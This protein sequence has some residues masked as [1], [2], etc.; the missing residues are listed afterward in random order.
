M[1]KKFPARKD[2]YPTKGIHQLTEET[3]RDIK[4]LEAKVPHNPFLS[5]VVDSITK[6]L[7]IIKNRLAGEH[8]IDGIYIEEQIKEIKELDPQVQKFLVEISKKE[9]TDGYTFSPYIINVKG[10]S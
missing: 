8:F 1:I 4:V 3:L 5:S 2:L 7:T 6:K 10:L 9:A